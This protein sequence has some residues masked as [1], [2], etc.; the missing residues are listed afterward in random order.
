LPRQRTAELGGP[1]HR[2]N[3]KPSCAAPITANNEAIRPLPVARSTVRWNARSVAV[4]CSRVVAAAEG[5]IISRISA[6]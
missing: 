2:P 1:A 5:S 6:S 3:E 4:H